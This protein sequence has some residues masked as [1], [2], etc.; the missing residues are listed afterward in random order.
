MIKEIRQST[1]E[2]LLTLCKGL[3]YHPHTDLKGLTGID[4]TGKI[5]AIIGY[6]GWTYGSVCLH[7]WIGHKSALSREFLREVCRYPASSG[8]KVLIGNTPA[9]NAAALR[10]NK[11]YGFKEVHRVRDGYAPGVD[12][13]IQELRLDNT[14]RWLKNDYGH[15]RSIGP[16][17]GEAKEGQCS[18]LRPD[19]RGVEVPAGA[20]SRDEIRPQPD[21][22][23]ATGHD[24]P[25]QSTTNG[26][27]GTHPYWTTEPRG[28]L[29]VTYEW[30]CAHC[31]AAGATSTPASGT[32]A[33]GA[34][35]ESSRNGP[36]NADEG[37]P[38]APKRWYSPAGSTSD[39]SVTVEPRADVEA[40]IEDM[41]RPGS[42]RKAVFLSPANA[43]RYKDLT[44][45]SRYEVIP[46]FDWLG[47]YLLCRDWDVVKE[48][49]QRARTNEPI[50]KIIGELILAGSGKPEFSEGALVAQLVTKDGAVVRESLLASVQELPELCLRWSDCDSAQIRTL[51]IQ[52]A[53]TRRQASSAIAP[54]QCAA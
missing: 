21:Q 52:D 23:S 43:E 32:A 39:E 7:S 17:T 49:M 15:E 36:S 11:H 40:Q 6:D 29:H 42:K 31:H 45:S 1:S 28:C 44:T 18:R 46:D 16:T 47:G 37:R 22:S 4:S 20:D 54:I 10:F 25:S 5:A 30:G 34:T 3:R 9:S 33:V 38:N 53:L 26:Y 41:L 50:R 13:I 14:C 51:S 27:G 24:R 19:G 2:E 48:A 35:P 12:L 8:R